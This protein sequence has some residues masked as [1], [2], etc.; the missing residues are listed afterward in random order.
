MRGNTPYL[1]LF[2]MLAGGCSASGSTPAA[3]AEAAAQ[4]AAHPATAFVGVDVIPM[5]REGILRDQTVIVR[6]ERIEAV[7]PRRR[8]RVPPDAR[9]IDGTGRYLVPGLVDMHV[10]FSR[11][12]QQGDLAL[13]LGN[14]VTTIRILDAGPIPGVVEW[15]EEVERGDRIAPTIVTSGPTVRELADSAAAEEVVRDHLQAGY[16]A[17]KVYVGVDA[18]PYRI[19]ARRAAE[20]GIPVVGHVPVAVDVETAVRSGQRTLEHAED[21]LQSY[22][23]MQMDPARIPALVRVLKESG[24]CVTPTLVVF[25]YVVRHAEQFPELKELMAR[26]E[27]RFVDPARLAAWS[28]DRNPYV[29]RWRQRAEEVPGYAQAFAE[30]WR[31]MHRIVAALDTAGVPILAGSDANI[32]FTL[33]GF[34]LHEELQLLVGGAGLTPFE[35]LRAATAT[36]A[37]CM[38]AERE[39]GAVRPGQRADLLLLT[40][41]P[42]NDITNLQRRVGVMARGRWLPEAVLQD[43]MARRVAR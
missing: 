33:P 11:P 34:S 14:G 1:A 43:R 37:E 17:I 42:L 23:K 18:E 36:P 29:R 38:G 21:L 8:V 31:F 2:V 19:L 22:F 24:A 25:G 32:A 35:A 10:H 15:R 9:R 13:Y 40:G 39:V 41:N 16:D 28:P 30:Q 12:E 26:P 5:D 6:G 3:D 20:L 4:E 27:L 7:G